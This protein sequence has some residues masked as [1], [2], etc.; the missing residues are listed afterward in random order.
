MS[1]FGFVN[2]RLRAMRSERVPPQ[3]LENL[4][5]M[6]KL[7]DLSDWM[8]S[9]VYG[10][11]YGKA[12]DHDQGLKAVDRA[13]SEKFRET[14]S[15][16]VAMLVTERG[17]PLGLYLSR[18]G[19]ENVKVA[20]RAVHQGTGYEGAAPALVPISPLD[21]GFLR[22]L[23]EVPDL[24]S[25]AALLMTVGHPAGPTLR[26]FLQETGNEEPDFSAMD[27]AL[28]RTYTSTSLTALQ[29]EESEELEPLREALQ[30]EVDLANLR[31]ALKVAHGGGGPLPYSPMPYGRLKEAFLARISESNSLATAVPHLQQTVFRKALSTGAEEAGQA[32]NLGSLERTLERIRFQRLAR[33]AIEDPTGLG[34]TLRFLVEAQ[35]E[36]QN[37]RLIARSVAGL[38]PSETAREAMILV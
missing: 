16:C 6:Q 7:G 3:Q 12:L 32:G 17:S 31:T 4:L 8:S 29:E 35:S 9:S 37:L 18:F 14:L 22:Q 23:C 30:D 15:R 13:V 24:D 38:I 1:D 28:E 10:A 33:R 26:R 20:V 19:Y 27:R 21:E 25:V 36:A 5:G 2:A 34:F 11:A